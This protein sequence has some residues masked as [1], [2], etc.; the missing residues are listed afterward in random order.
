MRKCLYGG[1]L[2]W[3]G[4][5]LWQQILLHLSKGCVSKCDQHL[6]RVG[7]HAIGRVL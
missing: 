5:R 2:L 4:H 7:V 3:R 1:P 6:L